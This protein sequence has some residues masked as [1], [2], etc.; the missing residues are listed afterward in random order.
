MK[1]ILIFISILLFT[2][3]TYA[4]NSSKITAIEKQ[5][6]VLKEKFNKLKADRAIES[7]NFVTEGDK[8]DNECN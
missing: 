1:K 2:V 6:A 8:L 3:T 4:D 5:R 7:N